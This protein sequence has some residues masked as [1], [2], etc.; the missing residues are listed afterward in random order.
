MLVTAKG[1]GGAHLW[2]NHI[3]LACGLI[4][5][6]AENPHKLFAYVQMSELLFSKKQQI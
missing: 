5:K 2:L 4:Y 3:I 6:T 1:R